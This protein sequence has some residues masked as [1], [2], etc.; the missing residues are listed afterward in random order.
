LSLMKVA[1]A[2]GDGG[3]NV[4]EVDPPKI[5]GPYDALCEN[6][7]CATCTGTDWQIIN[8]TFPHPVEYPTVLGHESV[9][10]VVEIGTSVRAFKVGD[11]VTRVGFV[12]EN[13][14]LHSHWGGMSQLAIARDHLTMRLDGAPR[15][16][17]GRYRVNWRI[18]EGLIEPEDA[19]MI[20]T[21]RETFSYAKRLGIR[22]GSRVLVSGSGANGF[23]IGRQALN[24][25]AAY[26]CLVGNI[27]RAN[28]A[29]AL[30]FS[31]YLDYKDSDARKSFVDKNSASMDYI[32]DA[33]GKLGSIDD[34]LPCIRPNG[35]IG[36]YGKD[37]YNSYRVSVLKAK[38]TFVFN[39]G[40]YDEMEAH[41]DVV[42]LIRAHKL[43]AAPWLDRRNVFAIGDAALAYEHVRAR[44][45]IKAIVKLN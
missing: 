33:T 6:L 5:V 28:T 42:D 32:I 27:D 21:W 35:V 24:L 37:D 15:P 45:A 1:V 20:I 31:E 7:F 11:L 23:S 40:G 2:N 16:D 39:S 13:P 17:Y 36:C 26:V 34:Y 43:E 12:S 9:A 14:S 4:R 3:L 10:R 38:T 30:A 41:H 22:K 18:P 19:T 29:Q 25:G 44:R 8:G